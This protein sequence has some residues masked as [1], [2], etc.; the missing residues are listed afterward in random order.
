MKYDLVRY[1][2]IMD[3]KQVKHLGERNTLKS[4]IAL[5]YPETVGI[6]AA[7]RIPTLWSSQ[8]NECCRTTHL[9]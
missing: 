8:D 5:S 9:T 6:L 3:D 4:I 2:N 1:Q 7:F